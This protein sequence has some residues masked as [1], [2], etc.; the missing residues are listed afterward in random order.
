MT[1]VA[2]GTRATYRGRVGTV[3]DEVS[4]LT[5]PEQGTQVLFHLVYDTPQPY[6]PPCGCCRPF[7]VAH[8]YR[9]VHTTAEN[10]TVL[11]PWLDPARRE[12]DRL[13][14]EDE[15]SH[16]GPATHLDDGCGR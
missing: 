9:G 12:A 4:H 16:G 6:G 10:L 13:A 14:V 2:P 7:G 3:A 11:K 15:H 8:H 5:T 1:G